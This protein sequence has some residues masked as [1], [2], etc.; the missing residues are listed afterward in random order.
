MNYEIRDQIALL[1]REP[2]GSSVVE[3]LYGVT[4]KEKCFRRSFSEYLNFEE[5]N[6]RTQRWWKQRSNDPLPLTNARAVDV[7]NGRG[8]ADT[9]E[10]DVDY[11]DDGFRIAFYVLGDKPPGI[12]DIDGW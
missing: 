9:L 1:R 3:V 10:M 11:F 6:A 12:E 7:M 5:A 2:D 8:L 4:I